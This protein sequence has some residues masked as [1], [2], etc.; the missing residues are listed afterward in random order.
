MQAVILAGGKGARLYPYTAVLPKP[1]VPIGDMPILEIVLRQL[2][3]FGYTRATIAVGHLASLIKAVFN[4]GHSLG[5]RIDYSLE[6]KPLGTVGPITLVKNLEKDFLMMNGDI[7]TSADF[8]RMMRVHER[9]KALLTVG[10]CT[11][12]QNI[13]SG[14]LEISQGEVKRYTEKPSV[15][16]DISAGIY[17]LNR[18]VLK[19]LVKNEYQDIPGLVNLLLKA[20]EKIAAYRIRGLWFDLGN[21]EDYQKTIKEFKNNKRLYLRTKG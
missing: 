5:L 12:Q 7:L 2:K 16:Y 18:G 11:C 9:K 1:L 14:V 8:A 19:Y 6:K 17:V 3:Y 13:K 15:S 4:D 10:A 21:P 20:G